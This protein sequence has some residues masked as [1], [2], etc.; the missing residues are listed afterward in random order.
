MCT[1]AIFRMVDGVIEVNSGYK[2]GHN[3]NPDYESVC[4]GTTG[5]AECIQVIFDPGKLSYDRLLEISHARP[6]NPKTDKEMTWE[7]SRSVV[8]YQ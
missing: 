6:H 3:F 8:L 7:L 5:Y 2:G 4:S 1:E